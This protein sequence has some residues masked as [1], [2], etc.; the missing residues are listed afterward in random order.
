MRKI[1]LILCILAIVI[2]AYAYLVSTEL[3]ANVFVQPNL[4]QNANRYTLNNISSTQSLL[5]KT[6]QLAHK[7][8]FLQKY[9]YPW[10]SNFSTS[11]FSVTADNNNA[12]SILDYEKDAVSAI[13]QAPG[14]NANNQPNS[15]AWANTIIANMQLNTF[16]NVNCNSSDQCHGIAINNAAIR[17]VPTMLPSYSAITEPGEGY[18]FDN[19]Q[20]STLWR[21]TPVRILQQSQDHRWLLIEL[22]GDLGWVK[23][24][25]I[26]YTSAQF[27]KQWQKRSYVTPIV[28]RTT[29]D[30]N[31]SASQP[32]MIYLGSLF[33]YINKT[34]EMYQIQLPIAD[35]RQQASITNVWVS[36]NDFTA[37]PLTPTPRNFNRLINQLL[38]MPYGWGGLGFNTD[39]SGTMQRLFTAFGIWIPRNSKDQLNFAGQMHSFPLSQYSVNQ[40]KSLLLNDTN[41]PLKPYLT[42]IGFSKHGT[43][44]DHVA[45]YLGKYPN[46]HPNDI[47]IFQTVWGDPIKCGPD[48]VGRAIL[49]KAVITTMNIGAELK[50][51]R[52]GYHV[53]TLWQDP[54]IYVTE[55]PLNP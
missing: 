26:A 10:S 55:I 44:I 30:P 19:L 8:I 45:L 11:V 40:R 32:K 17:T 33:P 35:A 16:P 1:I 36:N 53:C 4:S 46:K 47:V 42:L 12:V 23:A 37:W 51:G 21:G 54:G 2:F 39:C 15:T 27:M 20:E 52:F 22:A 50:L 3:P 13:Q 48:S 6:Q 29:L 24:D 38:G 34:P 25:A 9:Y 43:S 5:S 49:N 18:P 31:L 28:T 14:F 41:T 7:Q